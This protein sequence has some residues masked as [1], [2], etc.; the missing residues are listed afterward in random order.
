MS[1]TESVTDE[2]TKKR[3]KHKERREKLGQMKAHKKNK[4]MK[5]EMSTKKR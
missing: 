4:E 5:A 3:W 2:S 1:Y